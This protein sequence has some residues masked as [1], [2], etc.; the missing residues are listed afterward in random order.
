M[1]FNYNPDRDIRMVFSLSKYPNELNQTKVMTSNAK[2][3]YHFSKYIEEKT[4]IKVNP[5]T[6]RETNEGVM[7][8]AT[9]SNVI[10]KR[11]IKDYIT[12]NE[13]NINGDTIKVCENITCKYL[14]KD[15]TYNPIFLKEDMET[16]LETRKAV[17]TECIE[18]SKKYDVLEEEDEDRAVLFIVE[19]NGLYSVETMDDDVEEIYED[20][21]PIVDEDDFTENLEERLMRKKLVR[22]GKVIIKRKS[23]RPGYKFEGGREVRMSSKEVRD[24]KRAQMKAS[25]KRKAK[26]TGLQTL[27]KKSIGLR[28][29]RIGR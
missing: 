19:K 25:R 5:N 8:D 23:N 21:D 28:T 27:R 3:A 14:V 10:N 7:I 20:F 11:K 15:K 29:R 24:R 13:E 26:M 2:R 16:I 4:G 1:K 18:E 9:I 17:K 22:G 6:F 12:I